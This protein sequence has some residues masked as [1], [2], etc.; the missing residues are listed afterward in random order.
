MQH[1]L[2]ESVCI[3]TLCMIQRALVIIWMQFELARAE[4]SNLNKDFPRLLQ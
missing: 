4:R 1:K 3:N 2:R